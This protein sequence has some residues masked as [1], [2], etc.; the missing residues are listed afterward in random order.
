[1]LVNRT[2]EKL[3]LS[4]SCSTVACRCNATV[5]GTSCLIPPC[6]FGQVYGVPKDC[7]IPKYGVGQSAAGKQCFFW[8]SIKLGLE[9]LRPRSQCLPVFPVVAVDPLMTRK[10][11]HIGSIPPAH[12]SLEVRRSS[13]AP[14][15]YG[16]EGVRAINHDH[17]FPIQSFRLRTRG[18]YVW[19]HN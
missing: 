8:K 5:V 18:K 6:P 3:R 16:G 13:L 1:M 14:A 12:R 10:M 19:N 7:Q 4:S 2:L 17:G 9:R 11:H 15:G